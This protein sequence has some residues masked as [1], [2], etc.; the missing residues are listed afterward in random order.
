M[1]IQHYQLQI[2]LSMP[3]SNKSTGPIT[4]SLPPRVLIYKKMN[5][6]HRRLDIFKMLA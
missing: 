4:P 3:H 2:F 6:P 5:I 1:Y